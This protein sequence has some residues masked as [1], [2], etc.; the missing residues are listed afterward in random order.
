[1]FITTPNRILTVDEN[2]LRISV[3]L[4]KFYVENINLELNLD[5]LRNVTK[6]LSELT[7]VRFTLEKTTTLLSLYPHSRIELAFYGVADSEALSSLSFAVSNF[8]LGCPWPKY[9]DGVDIAKFL[10]VL[11][12]QAEQM[13]FEPYPPTRLNLGDRNGA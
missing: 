11:Q 6:Y 4:S 12:K 3:E 8:F 5:T 13:G 1:M 2:V 10:K 7:G 9:G